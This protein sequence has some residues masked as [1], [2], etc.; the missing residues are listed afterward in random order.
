[1]T[2]TENHT[3]NARLE[4]FN[5][6]LAGKNWSGQ[7]EAEKYLM[8]SI[9]GP[10]PAGVPHRWGWAET[11]EALDEATD[12]LGTVDTARRHLTCVNPGL[13][14]RGAI[15]THNLAAGFQLV[16]SGEICWS[17]RHSPGALRFVTQGHPEAYTAVDGEKLVMEDFDLLLTPR[18]S[19]HDHHNPSDKD[20]YWLDA[21]DVGLLQK[22]GALFYEPYGED[23]QKL[24]PSTSEWV[25][26]RSHWLRPTWEEERTTRLPLRYAWSDV[27]ER[28]ALYGN[29]VGSPYDGL[30]LRY[31]NPVTGGP[32]MDTIDCWVQRLVPG[33]SGKTHRRTSSAVVYVIAGNGTLE[34]DNGTITFQAGDVISLPNW[35]NFR[36]TNASASDEVLL[37]SV[38]DIPAYQ[39][40][41]LLYEEPEAIIGATPAPA[42]PTPPLKPLY[43]QGAF[44]GKDER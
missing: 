4:A 21:L 3:S 14:D 28:L 19:W 32:T 20:V 24:R 7:W 10:Q 8:A 25:G 40:L 27:R 13:K 2:T 30:A 23:S 37:F 42:N 35:T 17:H 39:R 41:G 11:K 6:K 15:T 34:T 22:L 16:K 26:T 33:F 43:A 12:V 18:F 5:E 1:M 38:H 31:A 29:E 36:W 9:G 44:Y